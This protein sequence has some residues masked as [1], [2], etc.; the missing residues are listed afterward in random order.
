MPG[1]DGNG[2]HGPD[3]ADIEDD[4]K[5]CEEGDAAETTG[6]E[7]AQD[8]VEGG[9]PGETLGGF[10]PTWDVLVMAGKDGK[11]V[12]ED[13]EDDSGVKK[14]ENTNRE[15]GTAEKDAAEAHVGRFC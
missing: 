15:V 3:E 4:G 7:N 2:D 11:E 13:A 10:D 5:E 12:G 6:E 1:H 9:C 14:L 8:A